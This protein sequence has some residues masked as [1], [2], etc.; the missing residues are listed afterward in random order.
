NVVACSKDVRVG[1]SVDVGDATNEST[2]TDF[3]QRGSRV[4]VN[5]TFAVGRGDQCADH[6]TYLHAVFARS[7]RRRP[8]DVAPATGSA[9][10]ILLASVAFLQMGR[11]RIERLGL[12]GP[13]R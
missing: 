9:R 8:M 4:A 2:R 7:R 3:G 11:P 13:H 5:A 10:G 1:R 12:A 6:R